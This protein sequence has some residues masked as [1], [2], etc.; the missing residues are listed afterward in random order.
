MT[1][2]TL[3]KLAEYHSDWIRMVKS[4]G[5]DDFTEDIVQ[6]MYIKIHTKGYN[7]LN[8]NGDVNKYYVY[9]TLKSILMSYLVQKSKVRK[10]NI[11][12]FLH[13]E[14]TDKLQEHKAF[15]ELALKI[16]NEIENWHWYDKDLF[17]LYRHSGMSI[18]KIA[19]GTSIS[20]VSIFNTLKN[21]KGKIKDK[22]HK[23][24]DQYKKYTL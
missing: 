20:W 4:M 12:D 23:D 7:A 14:D 16:D 17:E 6:E 22:L 19:A 1:K 5:G 15:H 3:E 18:R 8:D 11:D 10:V 9:L 24:Y 2:T 13:L 21:C